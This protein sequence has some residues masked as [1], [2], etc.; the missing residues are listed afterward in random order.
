MQHPNILELSRS[1]LLIIDMQEAFRANI[2]EFE[3]FAKRIAIAAKGA[4][5]LNLPILVTEQYPKGLGHTASEILEA[6]PHD[7]E[8]IE[9]TAFSSC[10]AQQFHDRLRPSETKQVLVS[11]IE[12]HICV[13]QTVHDLLALGLQVHLLTDCIT[14]RK[15]NDRT[16]ALQKML[17]SGAISSSVEMALFE[18][19]RDAKHEQFKAIQ[20]LIK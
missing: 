8:I 20:G 12:A 13:N 17:S 7:I 9:K 5:L 4:Q 10:G 1:A 14:S 2:Q 3:H 19:M 18:L 6:L 16:A 11:G 15:E